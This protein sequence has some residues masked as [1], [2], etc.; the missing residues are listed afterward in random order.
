MEN[1]STG[2]PKTRRNWII[3]AG[4]FVGALI[5]SISGIYFLIFP[6]GGYMGGRNPYYGIQILFDR[7]GWEWIH[8]WLSLGMI[9]IALVHIVLHWKWLVSTTKRVG[10]RVFL[11]QNSHMNSKGWQNVLVDGLIAV[12]FILCAASGVYFLFVGESKGGL[13]ADPMFLF[14]RTVWDLIHTWSGVL[15]ISGGIVHFAIH[16][17]WVTKVTR[18][19]FVKKSF[20][21]LNTSVETLVVEN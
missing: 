1:K 12:S 4:L 14:S 21:T 15:F 10:R 3:D 6:D 19:M 13:V 7:T 18:K 2:S 8:T 9:A 20:K 17:G 11:R 16:W 5:A